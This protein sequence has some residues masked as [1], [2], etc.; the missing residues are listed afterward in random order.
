MT[1]QHPTVPGWT[2]E[3][4]PARRRLG[5]GLLAGLLAVLLLFGGVGLFAA[6]RVAGTAEGAA[7]PEAAATGLADALG[8]GQQAVLERL[9]PAERRVL[10]AY[11]TTLAGHG[12]APAPGAARVEGLQ[13][14]TEQVAEGVAR[15]HATAGRLAGAKLG[16]SL[17]LG[18]ARENGQAPYVVA[19]RRDGT[20]Y[21]SLQFTVTDWMLTRAERERP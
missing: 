3:P 13:T 16:E 17:D 5:P 19:I 1:D 7:S 18:Q 6:R 9:S 11:A 21:P 4:P 14:R 10:T 15:V 20:W 2:A 12:G 8:R